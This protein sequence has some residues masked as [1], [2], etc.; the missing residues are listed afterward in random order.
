[1]CWTWHC[2]FKPKLCAQLMIEDIPREFDRLFPRGPLLWSQSRDK[3][4]DEP[5]LAKRKV[6]IVID[7]QLFFGHCRFLYV[8]V[9]QFFH[10]AVATCGYKRWWN[11]LSEAYNILQDS[12]FESATCPRTCQFPCATAFMHARCLLYAVAWA[13][14]RYGVLQAR[15]RQ[16]RS[17]PDHLNPFQTASDHFRTRQNCL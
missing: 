16:L 17:H 9:L 6:L 10:F 14:Q 12:A 11:H 7:R 4:N 1:M 13:L 3:S 8:S 2:S 5:R 15:F